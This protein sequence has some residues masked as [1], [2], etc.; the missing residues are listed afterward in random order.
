MEH[1]WGTWNVPQVGGSSDGVS[2]EKLPQSSFSHSLTLSYTCNSDEMVVDYMWTHDYVCPPNNY[3]GEA[4][5][6]VAGL[7]WQT[8]DYTYL[9]GTKYTGEYVFLDKDD[10]DIETNGLVAEYEDGNHAHDV[11]NG[12]TSCGVTMSSYFGGTVYIENSDPPY[13]RTVNMDYYHYYNSIDCG[14]TGVSLSA[15]GVIDVSMDCWDNVENWH[16][17]GYEDEEIA[18]DT[19][20]TNCT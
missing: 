14:I 7:H 5:R 10:G 18:N 11:S 6:D 2:T 16:I 13:S 12:S 8:D 9:K 15:D 1:Q 19:C 17:Q 20:C 4:P 3:D